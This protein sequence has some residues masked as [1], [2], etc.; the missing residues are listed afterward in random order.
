M[1]IKFAGAAGMVT[2]SAHVLTL[3]NGFRILFDCGLV[4]GKGKHVWDLNNTWYFDPKTIDVMILSHAHIDHSGRIPQLVKDGF[5]GPIHSTHAT[6]SLCAIMLLDSAKI[7]ERDV[8]WHNN[9]L[10][11][12]R[13]KKSSQFRVPLY[14]S[15]D[16]SPAMDKFV[17]HAYNQWFHIAKNIQV[18]F[19][20]QGHILGSASVT[21]KI[22]EGDKETMFGFTG[23]IGRPERPILRDPVQMPE[24]DF[25]ICESTYGDKEHEAPP[26]QSQTFL[27]IVKE[28]CCEKKGKLIIPA[29][30]IGR[31]QE[32]VY[33]LDQM[34]N[35]GLLP[36]IPVYVD[37]PLAVNATHIYGTHPECYDND[38]NEYMLMDPNPFG[39]ND[40]TYIRDVAE[41][42]ALNTSNKPCI[43]ISSSGMMNAG[44]V[45]HHLFNNIEKHNATFLI[46][47]YC[48]PDTPGGMLRD[49]IE[50]IKL[51]GKQKKVNATVKTMDSFSAHADR[52]EM[53]EFLSNQKRVKKI[54]LV[55][56]VP[57]RQ[58]KFKAYL[59]EAGFEK[60][61]IPSLG[62]EIEL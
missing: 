40:L 22:K 49:G 2:G 3:P 53:K 41:S 44:R 19:K 12:K 25:L 59:E 26:Q 8:E 51:F 13:K 1:H 62:D 24:V 15:E 7:Q 23:D 33:M 14:Q 5:D 35:N 36:K 31:T 32:I 6:R 55:H 57:D 43:I 37:S 58:V 52:K 11:K 34:E 29:F 50:V 56:G 10:R 20:D 47:G 9:K 60:V 30:S 45:K 54:F 48:S 42:K 61:I 46:V 28:A 39:F 27:S 4:Q 38:L 21:V 16:V 18:C 17:G